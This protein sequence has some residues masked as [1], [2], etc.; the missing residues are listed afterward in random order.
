MR[1]LRSDRAVLVALAL[2]LVAQMPHAA[3]LFVRFE[4]AGLAALAQA[5]AYALALESAAL[6]FVM[7][8]RTRAAL[9]FAGLSA[10]TNLLYYFIPAPAAFFSA[11]SV[12]RVALAVALPLAIALYSHEVE[13][14][15]RVQSARKQGRRAH[16]EQNGAGEVVRCVCGRE[17]ASRQG[18]AAHTRHCT[19]WKK[20]R[21]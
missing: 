19:V 21:V 3:R 15:Q 20:E 16:G 5:W 17:F 4:P 9:L 11:E 18:M 2:A 7:R 12:A 10:L 1:L 6:L 14:G 13:R 8:G